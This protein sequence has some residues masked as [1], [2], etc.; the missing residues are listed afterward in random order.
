MKQ[1]IS[2]VKMAKENPESLKTLV[3]KT[4]ENK[5]E[6]E[7]KYNDNNYWNSD[8]GINKEEIDEIIK[9]L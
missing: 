9:N 7:N 5:K 4:K 2:F 6:K 8:R 3:E 1:L